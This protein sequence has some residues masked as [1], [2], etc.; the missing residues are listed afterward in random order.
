MMGKNCLSSLVLA[1]LDWQQRKLSKKIDM[2]EDFAKELNKAQA[3]QLQATYE[4]R[5][6]VHACCVCV[7]ACVLCAMRSPRSCAVCAVHHLLCILSAGVGGAAKRG[8]IR[9][10]NL[11]RCR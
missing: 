4:E 8:R 2:W 9:Q 6:M 5:K 3:A 11:R 7:C 1:L 10:P